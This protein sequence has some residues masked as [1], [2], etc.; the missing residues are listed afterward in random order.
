M[1]RLKVSNYKVQRPALPCTMKNKNYRVDVE[2][3]KS[4]RSKKNAE[5][6]EKKNTI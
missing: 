1:K 4:K 3:R 2:I 5:K 6:E